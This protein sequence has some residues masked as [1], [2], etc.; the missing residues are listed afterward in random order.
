[1][2][3]NELNQIVSDTHS[4]SK[5][6]VFIHEDIWRKESLNLLDNNTEE[7]IFNKDILYAIYSDGTEYKIKELTGMWN[8]IGQDKN[9][10]ST[11][12]KTNYNQSSKSLLKH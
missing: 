3:G 12:W 9:Y 11:I 5:I 8:T 1:M 2:T 7:D 6:L 4:Y 10:G